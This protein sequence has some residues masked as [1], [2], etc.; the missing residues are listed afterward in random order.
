MGFFSRL[1]N[2]I[3]GLFGGFV[4]SIEEQNPAAV[5]EVTIQQQKQQYQKLKKASASIPVPRNIAI[6]ISLK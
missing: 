2:M 1:I 6:K 3:H 5:F 4:Y